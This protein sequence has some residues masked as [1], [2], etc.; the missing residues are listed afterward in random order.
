MPFLFSTLKIPDVKLV[1]PNH[2]DDNRGYFLESYKESEFSVNGINK[3]FVQDNFS[4]SVYGVLRGLHYQTKPK[5]QAK[6]VSVLSGEIFDVAV[7]IRKDSPTFGKWVGEKLSNKN[8][9]M[10]Y[11]PEGFAHGFCT[12]TD[13]A[14]VLYKVTNEYSPNDERGIIWNDPDI[15]ISWPISKPI[16]SEKDQILPTL[17]DT[18]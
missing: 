1:T 11:I 2:Y 6:L 4:H 9:K 18:N 10:L 13:T 17:E 14:D 5:E 12:L 8:H 7:D 16:I 15:S 3:K